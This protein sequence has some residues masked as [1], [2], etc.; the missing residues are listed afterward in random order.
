MDKG[1]KYLTQNGTK[2]NKIQFCNMLGDSTLKDKLYSILSNIPQ[3]I[4]L[5]FS[6]CNP[7][8]EEARAIKKILQTCKT[9]REL[10]I[11]NCNL[12]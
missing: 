11:S 1:M 4:C 6:H 8:L 2:L 9:I 12:D 7:S 3:L 10:D 5:N